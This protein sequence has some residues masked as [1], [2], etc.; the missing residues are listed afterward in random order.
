M[1]QDF[2]VPGLTIGQDEY[3]IMSKLTGLVFEVLEK[4]WASLDC[5]L[6][7]MKIEFGVTKKGSFCV[8]IS[9]KV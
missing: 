6:V 4:A 5:A 9:V 8:Q 7:D 1:E 3:A 2:K